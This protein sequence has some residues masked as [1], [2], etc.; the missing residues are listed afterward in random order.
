[1][2]I[3]EKELEVFIYEVISEFPDLNT[4]FKEIDEV[5]FFVDLDN[6]DYLVNAINNK[7]RFSKELVR[8]LVLYR[9]NR[10]ENLEH[11]KYITGN[12]KTPIENFLEENSFC[13]KMSL[14]E[15]RTD[16]LMGISKTLNDLYLEKEKKEIIDAF[17]KG[18]NQSQNF[19]S[20]LDYYNKTFKK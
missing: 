3:K 12:F 17:E 19:Q 14:T 1:M 20:G 6:N 10:N 5:L 16:V 11:I 2:L 15:E 4:N 7:N 8:D 9:R 13:I 18:K